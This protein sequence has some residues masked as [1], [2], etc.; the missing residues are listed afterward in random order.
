LQV[1]VI[2]P[3]M[4]RELNGA[5][6]QAVADKAVVL[7]TGRP[8]VFS[9]GFDLA[10]LTRGCAGAKDMVR[11]GFELAERVLS[12]PAP[13]VIACNGHAVAMGVFL[14]LAGDL[15]FGAAG[16]HKVWVNEVAL[17]ITVPRLGIEMC[18]QRLA[19]AYFNRAVINSES[20][21]PD[22]AVLAGFLDHAVPAAELMTIAQDAAA[23]LA[24]LNIGTH[25]ATKLRAREHAISAV[26]A[27]IEA[28]ALH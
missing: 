16:K 11:A 24:V 9:A 4:T 21:A 20:F 13:V 12:F 8:G 10:I 25:T 23:A 5:L 14:V 28:D 7:L 22:E 18:R 3:P 27:A 19:P 2:S 15:R 17:G 6:D 1:N 26:R